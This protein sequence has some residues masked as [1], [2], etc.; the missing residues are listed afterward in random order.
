MPAYDMV[1]YHSIRS[2]C[3]RKVRICLG[4]KGI[5][6]ESRV[7][8]LR[9]F[10]HHTPEYLRLN[11]NG[12][13]PTLVDDGRA[14]IESTLINEY[15][16][17]RYPQ[18]PLR[19]GHP[20]ERLQMRVWTKFVD[21]VCLPAVVVPTWTQALSGAVTGKSEEELKLIL[22]RI[23]L[24]E[25]RSRWAK[26]A[27]AGYTEAEFREAYDKMTL[28]LD[29]MEHALRRS[30][31]LTGEDYTLA[32]INMDIMNFWGRT[33]AIV[34]IGK[35]MT[36]LDEMLDAEAAAQG[37]VVRPDP[38]PEKGYFYRSDHF[39]LAKQGVPSLHFLHPGA[40][41]LNQPADYGQ[42]KRDEYTTTA[43]HK[44][45]DDVRADW[46]LG[47]AVEDAILLFRT[48]LNIAQG[49]TFPEWKPGTEFRAI[50][51]ERLG[52]K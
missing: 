7:L 23:P 19:P 26:I 25:R 49:S 27:G 8:D 9:K 32:D 11:P 29:R 15:L 13:V 34:S 2:T 6:F 17:E 22:A 4:E 47:G 31:W 39:E 45:S 50:R 5:E 18:A 40:E 51:A 52:R 10:E 44:P 28:A 43:Y 42:R 12:Y 21:D 1:L 46:D 33:H 48:G 14:L 41:Y 37:R 16:D 36:T 30:R 24:P 35:G 38:E 3:S 20:Y